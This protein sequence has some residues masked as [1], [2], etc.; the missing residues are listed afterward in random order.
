MA[1]TKRSFEQAL[2]E[3]ENHVRQLD[4]G[5][6]PLEKAL[7][8][9]ESGIKLQAECAELLDATEQR[10]T[11]LSGQGDSISEVSSGNQTLP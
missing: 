5:D 1:K 8:V 9:F 10:I 7:S 2:E 4:S 6:L 11:E 3:L